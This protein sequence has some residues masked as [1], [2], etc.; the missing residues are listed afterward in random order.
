MAASP[1]LYFSD[2]IDGPKTGWNGSATK[3]A[4]VTI[5]GKNFGYTRGSS[6]HV[7]VGG[8]DLTADS[9]YAEWGVTTN[10]ARGMERITFWLK[11]TCATGAGTIS[12]TVDGV[13]SNTVPFYVRT[14][15][16]I[17]FVDHTNGNDTNNGQTDT[18][19]WRTLG[20]ARQSISGGDILYIRAGT[21]TETD[22]NSRLLLLTG[23]FSG[24][25]NNYTALVGYPAEVAVLDAVPNAATRVIGTNYTYNGSVHHIVTSKLRILVYRGAWGAS[26]QPL[27][28]F[29]VIALDIDGQ[30]GTYPLVSTWA[31]VIDFHDQSDGTVYGCRLYGWGRDKFDH[32]IYLGED[33]SSVDLLNYDFGWNETHDLGPE[34]SGI[35]IHPQDTDANNK[36]ADNILI[37]DN[38]AYNLTHA[39]IILNSRYIN[40]YIYNNISY[41]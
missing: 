10:N 36:Y 39:G 40:V 28:H 26:Q 8:R 21:Y 32:F 37:H 19:A 7:T 24:S 12:V 38:L 4:A 2:L 31:G 34:V 6:N 41:H 1:A 11:D 30:N 35:Y 9:D 14:T 3:G 5:W 13:T 23:A 17:R 18:T 25:D 29:R 33:T 27:G 20:K 15:G 16:N 22:A